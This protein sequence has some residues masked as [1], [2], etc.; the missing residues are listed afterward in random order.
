[1]QQAQQQMQQAMQQAAGQCQGGGQG[2]NGQG[3]GQKPGDGQAGNWKP[4][5]GNPQQGNGGPGGGEAQAW[6]DR[7]GKTPSPYGT[8]AET[9]AGHYNDQG[10]HLASIYV[11]DKSVKG[12]AKLELQKAIEAAEA[13]SADDIDDS[14]VDRRTQEAVKRYF[15]VMKKEV[16]AQPE[17]K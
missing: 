13:D 4:G 12:E 1:M 16:A 5:Q 9:D 6:G 8:K 3:Q 14:R 2:Q 11:K 7:S 17:K 15:E 10:K